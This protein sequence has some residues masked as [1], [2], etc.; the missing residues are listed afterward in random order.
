MYPVMLN[1][2]GRNCLVVGAGG[3]ALRKVEG[4]V[5]EEARVTVVAP[6]PIKPL[7]EMAANGDI[8]LERRDYQPGEVARFSLGFAATD[9]REVN[10]QVFRDGDAARVWVNVADDPELS[11]FHLPARVKRG[12]LQLVVGSAGEA[13]FVV[14]RLRQFLERRFGSEWAEWMKAAA[15]FRK[16]PS[17]SAI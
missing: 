6:E 16:S 15:R 13:P 8:V 3:V 17:C 4:L 12:A 2:R 10:R 7:Q 5:S 14:R 11:T 9:D 1:L